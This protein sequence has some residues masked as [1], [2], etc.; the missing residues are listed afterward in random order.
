MTLNIWFMICV[1]IIFKNE[2]TEVCRWLH[3]LIWF[4]SSLKSLKFL[5]ILGTFCCFNR[6]GLVTFLFINFGISPWILLV[7]EHVLT[8]LRSFHSPF[9]METE[10]WVSEYSCPPFNKTFSKRESYGFFSPK[11]RG[12]FKYNIESLQSWKCIEPQT[13]SLTFQ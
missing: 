4:L 7:N 2:I 3:N 9:Q 11:K 8:N 13:I 5:Y 10:E 12:D 6:Y 1:S